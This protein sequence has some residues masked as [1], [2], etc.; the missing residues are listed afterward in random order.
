MDYSAAE[1][2]VARKAACWAATTAFSTAAKSADLLVA[3]LALKWVVTKTVK[4]DEQMD[5]LVAER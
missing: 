4:S 5:C 3:V 2:W 1:Q